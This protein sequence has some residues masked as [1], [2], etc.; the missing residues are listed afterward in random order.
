MIF[1]P[2]VYHSFSSVIRA[3][4]LVVSNCLQYDLYMNIC[5]LSAWHG[6]GFVDGNPA[7]VLD[8]KTLVG[9]LKDEAAGPRLSGWEE[10]I[11]AKNWEP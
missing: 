10:L 9:T 1:S 8:S 11:C 5:Y 3:H 4:S 7:C 6:Q 2:Q